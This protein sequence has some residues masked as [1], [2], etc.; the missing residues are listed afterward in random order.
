LKKLTGSVRFR[1]FKP[2]TEKTK[3][4]QF[5]LVFVLKNQTKLKFISLNWFRFGFGFFNSVWL[6]FYENQT[7]P[8]INTPSYHYLH[9]KSLKPLILV[10]FKLEVVASKNIFKDF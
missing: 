9:L 5:E 3:P 8:K 4:N 10:N 1:F 2:G 7:E 6:F